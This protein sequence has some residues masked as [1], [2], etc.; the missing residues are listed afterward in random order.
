MWTASFKDADAMKMLI[1]RIVE[2]WFTYRQHRG[3]AGQEHK[4]DG[5]VVQPPVV[6]VREN[7]LIK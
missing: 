5:A 6:K 1:V 3:G 2:K 4:L 7:L